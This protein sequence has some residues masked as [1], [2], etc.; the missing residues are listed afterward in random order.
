MRITLTD[1]SLPT[2]RSVFGRIER[3]ITALERRG[4]SDVWKPSLLALTDK[5]P[6]AP[7]KYHY[8]VWDSESKKIKVYDPASEKWLSTGELT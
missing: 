6:T 8:I 2:L 1:L 4:T 5:Q 7:G 3:V